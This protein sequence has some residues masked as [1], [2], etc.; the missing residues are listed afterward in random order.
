[1]TPGSGLVIVGSA[2][3]SGES[4]AVLTVWRLANNKDRRPHI[5][6]LLLILRWLI[7]GIGLDDELAN[8]VIGLDQV[9]IAEVHHVPATV[10]FEP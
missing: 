5:I 2:R 1:M 7:A 10:S 6:I 9:F 4:T 3:V 8:I